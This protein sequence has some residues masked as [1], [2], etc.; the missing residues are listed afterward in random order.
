MPDTEGHY[1]IMGNGVSNNTYRNTLACGR[2]A[3]TQDYRSGVLIPVAGTAGNFGVVLVNAPG[4]GYTATQV[5]R[6]NGASPAGT[7]TVAIADANTSGTD[8]VNTAAIAAGNYVGTLATLTAG[9]TA[10]NSYQS[11]RL[12]PTT[13]GLFP[14]GMNIGY[15]VQLTTGSTTY[16]SPMQAAPAF[17]ATI[18]EVQQR[19]AAGTLKS[20]YVRFH[21][22]TNPGGVGK[23]YTLTVYK[24]GFATGLAVTISG[25]DTS[26]NVSS[27]V[28]VSE[29]DVLAICI[30][31][32]GTPNAVRCIWGIAM[33]G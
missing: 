27:D 5:V 29:G 13:S 30:E 23:Q 22:G 16:A 11:C 33:T 6:V 1:I 3:N 17:S 32:S 7:P 20:F 10:G 19:C 14:V 4:A 12:A 9:G 31:P 21:D 28:S 25:T 18:D 24:N 26:G 15:S 8:G 2:A